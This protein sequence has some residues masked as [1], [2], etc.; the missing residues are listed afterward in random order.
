MFTLEQFSTVK[1]V[2]LQ[3]TKR[4]LGEHEDGKSLPET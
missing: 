1:R 2:S 4:T 3:I